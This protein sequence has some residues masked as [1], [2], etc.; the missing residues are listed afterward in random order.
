MLNINDVFKNDT[1]SGISSIHTLVLMLPDC[2]VEHFSNVLT[3]I[4]RADETPD[5]DIREK[6]HNQY[7][8]RKAY[9]DA[10]IKLSTRDA[11]VQFDS[12]GVGYSFQPILSKSP[13][14]RNKLN[15]K[16]KVSKVNNLSFTT[17]NVLGS[18]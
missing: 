8:S 17:S 4:T 7:G 13:K 9:M 15:L 6:L 5:T 18:E 16:T 3:W 14:F 10:I 1:V 2:P 12:S 11:A